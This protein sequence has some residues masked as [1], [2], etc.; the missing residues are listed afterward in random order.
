MCVNYFGR[1]TLPRASVSRNFREIPTTFWPTVCRP[2][3]IL[4]ILARSHGGLEVRSTIFRKVILR[5]EADA[6]IAVFSADAAR[7]ATCSA[8]GVLRIWDGQS[9]SCLMELNTR[10][11]KISALAFSTDSPYV[12]LLTAENVMQMWDLDSGKCLR[13]R[14]SHYRGSVIGFALVGQEVKVACSL[15]DGRIRILNPISDNCDLEFA[16]YQGTVMGGALSPDGT[17]LASLSG[18]G[19]LLVWDIATEPRV[20]LRYQFFEDGS[21]ACL[22]VVKDGVVQVFRDAWRYLGWFASDSKGHKIHFPIETSG[23]LKEFRP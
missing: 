4:A 5:L 19:T 18:D 7:V 13:E 2:M 3:V 10:R 16:S 14:T 8:D 1:G 17:Q 15:P 9:G 20:R 12:A 21:W 23:A 11:K 22:D 6:D